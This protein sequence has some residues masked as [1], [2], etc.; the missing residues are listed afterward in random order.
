MRVVVFGYMT[1]GRRTIEAVLEAGHD[2]PLIVTHPDG[3]N[4]YEKIFNEF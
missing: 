2:V 1:W 4:A 3:D